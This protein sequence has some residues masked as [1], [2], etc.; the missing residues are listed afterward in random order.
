MNMN[1]FLRRELCIC[2]IF[3]WIRVLAFG[4]ERHLCSYLIFI[5]I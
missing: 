2:F 1:L 3:L 5:W 4:T